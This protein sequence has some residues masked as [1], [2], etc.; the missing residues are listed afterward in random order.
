MQI[1]RLTRRVTWGCSGRKKNLAAKYS[2]DHSET[3]QIYQLFC[4]QDYKYWRPYGSLHIYISSQLL[5]R[6]LGEMVTRNPQ[7]ILDNIGNILHYNLT[8]AF[9]QLCTTIIMERWNVQTR[10][11]YIGPWCIIPLYTF[12]INCMVSVEPPR[13]GGT[14][15]PVYNDHPKGILL[16]L[17]ELIYVAKGHQKA[18]IVSKSKSVPSVFIKT[19]YWINHR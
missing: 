1:L 13:F 4:K 2:W 15:K 12:H 17:L 7:W 18:D 5:K 3:P 8:S 6:E 16:C 9:T 11:Y 14:V 19:H 10:E